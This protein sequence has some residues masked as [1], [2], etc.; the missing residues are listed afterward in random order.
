MGIKSN[1]NIKI[2]KKENTITEKKKDDALK[3]IIADFSNMNKSGWAKSKEVEEKILK[4]LDMKDKLNRKE[5]GVYQANYDE[6]LKV[7]FQEE[8]KI[9][10]RYKARKR[11]NYENVKEIDVHFTKAKKDSGYTLVYFL[12]HWKRLG[13]YVEDSI[14]PLDKI[15]RITMNLSN[16]PQVKT[17]EEKREE[18]KEQAAKVIKRMHPNLFQDLRIK[19]E[20]KEISYI[21]AQVQPLKTRL[22]AWNSEQIMAEIKNAIENNL[23]YEYGWWGGR[24]GNKRMKISI[25]PDE[26][27]G[28]RAYYT[29]EHY[30]TGR[31]KRYLLL[32]EKQIGFSDY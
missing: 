3:P 4:L 9:R 23:P 13:Y 32:N 24:D 18:N 11:G 8:T 27:E 6:Y 17:W 14:F 1:I 30:N 2:I 21:K 12:R 5:G 26:K 25:I 22:P 15:K 29:S 31:G 16:P 7:E 28:L 10:Y 20:N 19:I